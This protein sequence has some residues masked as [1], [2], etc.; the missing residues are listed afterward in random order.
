[1]RCDPSSAGAR[2]K[3]VKGAGGLIKRDEA[4]HVAEPLIKG[5]GQE[6][7][8]RAGTENV[9]AIAAFGA[10][11]AESR[12]AL[13]DEA[14]HMSALRNRLETGLRAFTPEAVMLP[15][16]NRSGVPMVQH[17]MASP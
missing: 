9:A 17:G 5:G 15:K 6:R 10:A 2:V 11:A 1:M 13:A 3:G 8:S 14:A 4:L 16:L 7:G 12:A